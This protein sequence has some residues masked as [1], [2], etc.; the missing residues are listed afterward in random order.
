MI[1]IH[2]FATLEIMFKLHTVTFSNVYSSTYKFSLPCRN[3][4]SF[5]PW[6][7]YLYKTLQTEFIFSVHTFLETGIINNF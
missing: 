1:K 7:A 2:W 4:Y 6:W 3:A 5:V